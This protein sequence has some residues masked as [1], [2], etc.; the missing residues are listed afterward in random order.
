MKETAGGAGE[1]SSGKALDRLAVVT[2]KR[3]FEAW[4]QT[5]KSRRIPMITLHEGTQF[6]VDDKTLV[7][8]AEHP[9]YSEKEGRTDL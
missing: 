1:A 6:I 7:K 8:A 9:E 5:E 3:I 4:Q 2:N